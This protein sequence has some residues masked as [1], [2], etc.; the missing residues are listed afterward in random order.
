MGLNIDESLT[1]EGAESELSLAD[2]TDEFADS[3]SGTLS[4]ADDNGSGTTQSEDT[5]IFLHPNRHS[6]FTR[7]PLFHLDLVVVILMLL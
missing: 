2:D 3:F 4:F 6:L 7:C 5:G 1:S